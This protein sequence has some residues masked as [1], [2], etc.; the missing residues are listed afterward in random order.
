[1]TV[2]LTEKGMDRLKVDRLV[3]TKDYRLVVTLVVSLEAS[4]VGL[5][6]DLLEYLWDK[7]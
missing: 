6:A 5:K 4:L 2:E 3:E 1:M 7:H